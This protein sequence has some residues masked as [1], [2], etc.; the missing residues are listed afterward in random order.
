[1][2]YGNLSCCLSSLPSFYLLS[3][4]AVT[5]RQEHPA[6][7]DNLQF[8]LPHLPPS[9]FQLPRDSSLRGSLLLRRL[10]PSGLCPG[11]HSR[12]SNS[13]SHFGR[14]ISISPQ[15]RRGPPLTLAW[16]QDGRTRP[17]CSWLLAM[18][19]NIGKD[20]GLPGSQVDSSSTR[21][22][23]LHDFFFFMV[24]SKSLSRLEGL[25]TF[26]LICTLP[27]FRFI[28]SRLIISHLSALCCLFL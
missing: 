14:G 9:S 1:M 7:P 27:L 3:C 17:T 20:T 19:E 26:Y 22:W 18:S 16:P 13:R 28:G 5:F 12:H 10:P 21:C 23:Q 2:K 8:T 6:H 11:T 15:L 24:T 25:M 4:L